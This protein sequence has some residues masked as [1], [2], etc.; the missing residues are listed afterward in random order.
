MP[1]RLSE[2]FTTLEFRVDAMAA[3]VIIALSL[4]PF[5]LL[6]NSPSV[7]SVLLAAVAVALRRVSPRVALVLVWL[8]AAVQVFGNERPTVTTLALVLVI[9]ASAS[10]GTRNELIAGLVSSV[11]GG[12]IAS[13]YLANTG[14]R[15][16][17]LL[18]GSPGQAAATL[19]APIGVLGFAWLAGLTVRAFRSRQDESILR[20]QA[21]TETVQALD[22]AEGERLRAAMARDVHDIVGHSLAVI[23]AQADSVQF[24]DD[25]DRIRQVTSTI[26]DTAR[27]SLGEVREVL[28]GTS[29]GSSGSAADEPHDLTAIIEQVTAAGVVVDHVTRGTARA[30]EPGQALVL[31]RV[32]QELL[33]NALRH[34][35]PGM[36][37]AFTEL[38]RRDDVVLEVH[39]AVLAEADRPTPTGELRRAGTGVAG[40]T[41][42]LAA[43]G[44]TLEAEEIDG[45][46]MARARIPA[47]Q[48]V[49][50]SMAKEA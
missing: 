3:V 44:G 39:N 16:A 1:R 37:I 25:T 15:F 38:W 41:A 11:I 12:G 27:R 5:G 20:V 42:R 32:A 2:R 7:A 40:M 10:V 35:A 45:T 36:P 22:L 48:P 43:I 9:Y 30:L 34:G 28:S 17:L 33:T 50:P 24:L 46:F 47:T 14:T 8:M 13:V 31:R 18:Y 19:L 29:A 4:V 23:I 21:Q 49:S 26:A 6:L